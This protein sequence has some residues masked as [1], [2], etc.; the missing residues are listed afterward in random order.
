MWKLV[1]WLTQSKC[2]TEEYAT[3]AEALARLHK[4]LDTG[5]RAVA[6]ELDG[7]NG[8]HEGQEL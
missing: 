2:V 8:K 3:E 6:W 1:L 7:P 4:Q 5:M